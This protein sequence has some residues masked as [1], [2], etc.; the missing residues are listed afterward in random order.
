V[1]DT[2]GELQKLTQVADLV[3]VGKS[4]PP[5]EGGQTPIEAASL[6]KPLMFGPGMSN[7]RVAAASLRECGA[8]ILVT[9][10]VELVDQGLAL[11]RDEKRRLEMATAARA[12]HQANQGAME[13]TWQELER[14]LPA[15]KK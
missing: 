4:L 15:G 5:N 12:W 7:F 14:H 13:R 10:E 11:L 9:D 6:G 2:T 8:A 3:F 1:A